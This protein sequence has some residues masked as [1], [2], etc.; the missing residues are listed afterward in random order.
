MALLKNHQNV[1]YPPLALDPPIVTY[2][3]LALGTP[4]V[5]Y[6]PLALGHRQ[7]FITLVFIFRQMKDKYSSH[8][9]IFLRNPSRTKGCANEELFYMH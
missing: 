6:P 1:T 9:S 5:T 2:P 4:I 3:P 8:P 7:V